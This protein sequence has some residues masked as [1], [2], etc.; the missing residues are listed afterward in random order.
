M[1][2]LANSVG[3]TSAVQFVSVPNAAH[4]EAKIVDPATRLLERAWEK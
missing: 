4:D 1:T 3:K 2:V